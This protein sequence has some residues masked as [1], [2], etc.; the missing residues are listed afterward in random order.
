MKVPLILSR[1]FL[2]TSR[3]LID[4]ERRELTLRVGDDKVQLS[5]YQKDNSKKEKEECM[6]I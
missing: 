6:R 1:P 2:A 3:A 5:I 4:V